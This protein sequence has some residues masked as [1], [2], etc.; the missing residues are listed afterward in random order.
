ML[1]QEGSGRRPERFKTQTRNNGS[2]PT[3]GMPRSCSALAV[4]TTK[5]KQWSEL[6]MALD[7]VKKKGATS[8]V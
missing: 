6:S 4:I 5:L 2:K 8:S 7:T 1:L 3:R